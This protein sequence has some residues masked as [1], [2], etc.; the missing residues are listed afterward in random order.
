MFR[1]KVWG[2]TDFDKQIVIYE[3]NSKTGQVNV[4]DGIE[5]TE[6]DFAYFKTQ[7]S[8]YFASKFKFIKKDDD[9]TL[10]ETRDQIIK[11]NDI[12]KKETK[13]LINFQKQGGSV[14]TA[15]FLFEHFR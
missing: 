2:V 1:G 3:N 15:L 8:F 7:K 6:V 14:Q 13:G 12:L 4:W 11:D 10:E 9:K 5:K